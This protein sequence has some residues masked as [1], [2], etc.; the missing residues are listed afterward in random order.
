MKI[1]YAKK[2][3]ITGQLKMISNAG[4]NYMARITYKDDRGK[5][6]RKYFNTKKEC[7]AFAERINEDRTRFGSIAQT[8][9]EKELGDA[10]RV[11]SVCREEGWNIF[12]VLDF[13][14]AKATK[15]VSGNDFG[16]VIEFACEKKEL[17]NKTIK[18]IKQFQTAV[19]QFGR[20]IGKT[21][22]DCIT[23]KK[24]INYLDD[25]NQ[26]QGKGWAPATKNMHRAHLSNMFEIAKT[27][28]KANENP[29]SSISKYNENKDR[30]VEYVDP[31]KVEQFMRLVKQID[32]QIAVIYTLVFWCGLRL[33]EASRMTWEWISLDQ[34]MLRVPKEITKTCKRVNKIPENALEWLTVLKPQ[35]K[36]INLVERNKS[37]TE[38]TNNQFQLWIQETDNAISAAHKRV[39]WNTKKYD[40]KL[41][42]NALRHSFG[43]FHLALY[44]NIG[45]TA[46]MMGNSPEK[47]R[48]NYDGECMDKNAP[49]KFFSIK[50]V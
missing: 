36:E 49:A 37:F 11:I 25:P 32:P 1:T 8:L 33:S 39:R 47:I 26:N 38:M 6:R 22:I 12:E 18:H 46:T 20:Y 23:T 19:K 41:P 35:V 16:E 29:V 3:P 28:E 44:D 10:A 15:D 9:T 40:V 30:T 42:Q 13:Y 14:R 48:S 24:I 43:T 4:Y 34:G 50:P 21:T 17:S 31:S 2:D 7:N 27:H 45:T 5:T